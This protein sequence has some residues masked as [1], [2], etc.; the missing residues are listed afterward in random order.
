[1]MR[2]GI[3]QWLPGERTFQRHHEQRDRR[4]EAGW[5]R[6]GPVSLPGV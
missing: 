1:M 5:R 4:A 6:L 2:S 3:A